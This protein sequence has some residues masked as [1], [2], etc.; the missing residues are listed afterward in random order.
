MLVP[1]EAGPVLSGQALVPFTGDRER[2]FTTRSVPSDT[3]KTTLRYLMSRDM[4][5]PTLGRPASWT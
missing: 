4:R 1:K 5:C 3:P 2:Y